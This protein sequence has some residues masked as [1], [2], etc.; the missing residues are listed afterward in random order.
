MKIKNLF[1]FIVCLLLGGTIFAQQIISVTPNQSVRNTTVDVVISGSSTNF[2]QGT[3]S[4]DQSVWFDQATSTAP[5]VI[6]PNTVTVN[7]PTTLTANFTFTLSHPAGYY[8]VNVLNSIDG[9][10]EAFTAFE[11][12]FGVGIDESEEGNF[13][14]NMFPVPASDRLTVALNLKE[15]HQTSIKIYDLNGKLHFSR[16]YGSIGPDNGNIEIPFDRYNLSTGTYVVMINLDDEV[17]T[18]SLIVK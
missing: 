18:K 9:H 8:D 14:V 5:I 12:I 6:L 4:I 10:L 16:N 7:S 1:P 11:I 13:D 2:G 3:S 17:L 15:E